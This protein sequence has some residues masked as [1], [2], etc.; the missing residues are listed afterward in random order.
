MAQGLLVCASCSQMLTCT[1][2]EGKNT[3]R[4]AVHKSN[5]PRAL[6][7]TVSHLQSTKQKHISRRTCALPARTRQSHSSSQ[8]AHMTFHTQQRN[9]LSTNRIPP[10]DARGKIMIPTS[11]YPGNLG[12]LFRSL[13][14]CLLRSVFALASLLLHGTIEIGPLLRIMISL[15]TREYEFLH[16]PLSTMIHYLSLQSGDEVFSMCK[17]K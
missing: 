14:V 15:Q 1:P 7:M 2:N 8:N 13:F 12:C 9:R 16:T 6:C 10:H 11:S 17:Y 4:H 5:K 3:C